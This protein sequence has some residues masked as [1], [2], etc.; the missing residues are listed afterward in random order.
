[1]RNIILILTTL[2]ISTTIF[3]QKVTV[4]GYAFEDGNRGFLNE[5]K[6]IVLEKSS[7]AVR[8]ETH[9]NLEGFFTLELAPETDYIIQASKKVFKNKEV[10][11][12]TKGTEA[13]KKAFTKVELER[14]PGYL[15]D[16]TMS[17][18][19]G[20]KEVVDAIQGARIEVYNNT[21]KKESLVLEEY[22][23]PNFNVT[24]E[25][26]NHYTI[27]I[28]KKDFFT[29]RM[30]AYVNVAGC[31]L[32]F[33]GVGDVRPGVSNVMTKNNTRGTLLANVELDRA[34]LNESIKVDNIYF[35]LAKWNIRT[36]AAE[37]LDKLLV[38]LKDNPSIIVELGSHTDCRGRDSYNMDL[39]QKR[40]ESSVAYLVEGGID[41]SRIQAKGYG[42][43]V[44]VNECANGVRCSE[45]RH[46]L[47]RRTELKILGFLENDPY[48][49]L[50][51]QEIIEEET[52]M[53]LLE[54]VQNQEIIQVQ[55][56]DELPEEI[57]KSNQKSNQNQ[58]NNIENETP[59]PTPKLTEKMEEKMEEEVIEVVEVVEVVK[60]KKEKPVVVTKPSTTM[61][62]EV[63]K[64]PPAKASAQKENENT[65]TVLTNAG[66]NTSTHSSGKILTGNDIED[67]IQ[68]EKK[69]VVDESVGNGSL[70]I[71]KSVATDF[72]GYKVQILNSNS[73]LSPSHVIFT[74]HGN[75]TLEETKEGTFSYLLGDFKEKKDAVQ[76]LEFI[77]APR[78]PDGK[79]VSYFKG[80]RV[81]L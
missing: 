8:G 51:L 9:S 77:V 29:K 58:N 31:I 33:D 74:Q 38:T 28:R 45:R 42:E 37:E 72:T 70:R 57:K 21:K 62:T 16:V 32:C 30:E 26:G 41:A 80:R 43:T 46:Q 24:F 67:L 71:L 44:L 5:V 39:S 63:K 11:F 65:E 61:N 35:D 36:D 34:E 68:K 18:K 6:I 20:T 53:K 13:G 81:K 17:E 27:M 3:S 22:E 55:E 15:F 73:K 52:M 4:E 19:R 64:T 12:T 48:S 40:A 49:K 2:F 59:A 60:V 66:T 7:R 78:Y 79:V 14:K 54:E 75:L 69:I 23:H 1:M 56:G 50:S 76:F 10:E 47:N 25:Q